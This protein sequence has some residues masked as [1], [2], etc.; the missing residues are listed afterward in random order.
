MF[1]WNKKCL[2]VAGFLQPGAVYPA[3]THD[4]RS[5]Y[6]QQKNKRSERQQ[7][8]EVYEYSETPAGF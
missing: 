1:V 5:E 8:W 7:S 3:I 2:Q 6:N 4:P